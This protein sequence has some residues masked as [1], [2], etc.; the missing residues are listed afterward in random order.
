M[1][2]VNPR[3]N[4]MTTRSELRAQQRAAEE[5]AAQ[6]KK[7]EPV[8][9]PKRRHHFFNFWGVISL[10]LL[11]LS[12]IVNATFLNRSFVLHEIKGSVVET[13]ITDQVNAG[14][15]Q[16]GISGSVLTDKE[17]DQLLTQAVNQVYAGKK[18]SLDLS[19]VTA[20][21]GSSVDSELSQYGLS[22]VGSTA[23]A[24]ISQDVNAAVNSQV[25]NSAVASFTRGVQVARAVT[26]VIMIGSGLVVVALLVLALLRRHLLES[27]SHACIGAAVID[28]LV[29]W[30]VAK[31][32]PQL[33]ADSP[34]YVSFVAQMATD[35]SHRAFGILSLVLITGLG[36]LAVRIVKWGWGSRR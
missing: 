36:L 1:P 24:A 18:I 13:T 17:T 5:E 35:F 25:N 33:A 19:K 30:A 9:V 29:V 28:G 7:E 2:S 10:V 27:A 23:T 34:D 12:L 21:V 20:K 3:S 4:K 22:G 11:L 8:A 32:G 16:Y 14:L 31:L 15:E 6:E 26:N